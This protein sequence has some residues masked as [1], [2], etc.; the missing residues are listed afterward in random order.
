MKLSICIPQ[1]NRINYLLES[2]LII[3]DQTYPNI[4]IVISDDCSTDDTEERIKS[5]IPRH[6][7]PIIFS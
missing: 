1:Y 2:L 6:K 5:L 7:Y 3:E 4:E